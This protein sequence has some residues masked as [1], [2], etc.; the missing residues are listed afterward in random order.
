[1][2]LSQASNVIRDHARAGRLITVGVAV[3]IE[4]SRETS[5][6]RVCHA[7]EVSGGDVLSITERQPDKVNGR[8]P[9]TIYSVIAIVP[10]DTL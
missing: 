1:M 8:R 5:L 6:D 7:I 4:L 2:D 3:H 10:E 9:N